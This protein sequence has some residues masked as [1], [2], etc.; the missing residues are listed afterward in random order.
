M[1]S[2]KHKGISRRHFVQHLSMGVGA[3]SAGLIFP[4]KLV[5]QATGMTG[6]LQQPKRI[7][8]L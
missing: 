5:A 1:G 7:L 4:S 8:V 2:N 6:A 3:V